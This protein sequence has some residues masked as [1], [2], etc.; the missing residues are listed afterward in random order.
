MMKPTP[1]PAASLI[2]LRRGGKHRRARRR[3]PAG[4]AQPG[5]ELHA[6]RLGVP[7][8]RRR[9]RRAVAP[10]ARR[11]DD[12]DGEELAHRACAVRELREEA[13]IELPADAELRPWSRWITPEVVPVRFD[14]RFYVA[15]APPH[16]PP[17]A[18]RRRDHRG[19]LDLAG[20][21][22]E[23]HAAGELS[24][25]FPTIKHLESLLPYSERRRGAGSGARPPDRADRAARR[26]RGPGAARGP[27]GEPGIL[28]PRAW[29][30]LILRERLQPGVPGTRRVGVDPRLLDLLAHPLEQLAAVVERRLELIAAALAAAATGTTAAARRRRSRSRCRSWSPSRGTPG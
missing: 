2:L 20:E 8:R 27:P 25:V 3:G 23:R 12:A 30:G 29:G 5:G 19:G 21:A 10:E 13:G 16:S 7:G 18:R 24:L 15:L 9:G 17:R 11:R 14:T 22:L 1:R 26:G 4:A 28:T 6:R